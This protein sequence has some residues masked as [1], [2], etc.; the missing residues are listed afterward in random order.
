LSSFGFS[1]HESATTLVVKMSD[2]IALTEFYERK[3]F[4]QK[5]AV[6]KA[7]RERERERAER[8]RERAERERAE[9]ERER[10]RALEIRKME[11]EEK[12]R[13]I[14]CCCSFTSFISGCML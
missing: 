7:E 13:G 6:E 4:S 14:S 10:E 3:G 11:H 12:M 2:L 8:E 9:R 5:E 1:F